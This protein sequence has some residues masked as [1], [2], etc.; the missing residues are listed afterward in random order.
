MIKVANLQMVRLSGNI[1]EDPM[2]SH[3]L[4]KAENLSQLCTETDATWKDLDRLLLALKV[5]EGL[6]STRPW[7]PLEAKDSHHQFT[8]SEKMGISFLQPRGPE[9]CQG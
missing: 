5:E 2:Q 3:E 8:A 7:R 6:V 9:F 1:Q 4:S